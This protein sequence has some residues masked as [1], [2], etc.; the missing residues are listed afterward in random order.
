M[1][2]LIRSAFLKYSFQ[3]RI[4]AMD[5]CLIAYH[6]TARFFGF[7]YTPISEME[8]AVYGDARLGDF[9]FKH[10]V[11]FLEKILLEAKECYPAESVKLTF[12]ADTADSEDV[13]RVFVEP[14]VEDP[15]RPAVTLLELRGTN[16]IDGEAQSK[17]RLPSAFD[18][19]GATWD[20]GYSI[21][22]HTGLET[23]DSALDGDKIARLFSDVRDFQSMFN[24]VT[25]PIGVDLADYLGAVERAAQEGVEQADEDVALTTRFPVIP[26][27][28][29][30][31][32]PSKGVRNLRK[33]AAKGKAEAAEERA[34]Q[35][36]GTRRIV[37][38]KTVVEIREE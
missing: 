28:T 19:N 35:E 31:G 10:S 27:F 12:A 33:L 4:G 7:Q 36:G 13:L 16:Y 22:K 18:K 9:I 11:G 32:S 5:G 3:A 38:L 1:Q 29:Y 30:K 2:D 14:V 26:G 23:G 15:S 25:L 34:A 6:S 8:E 20:V 24:N 21:V 17:V 37:Q